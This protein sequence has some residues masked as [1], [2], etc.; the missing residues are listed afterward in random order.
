MS[1]TDLL[2]LV[3]STPLVELPRLSPKPGIRTFAKLEGQ[4]PTGSVKDRI[5]KAL[6]EEGEAQGLLNPGDT[7]VEASS[8][9]T[10]I[11]L[12]F[13][14]RQRGY[15]AR[16]VL[17]R[18]VAPSI[19]D[20]LAIYDV[21]ITWCRH[22]GGMRRAIDA[23]EEI[24]QAEGLYLLGQFKREA[25]V[26][27][28]YLTTGREIASALPRID[29]FVAGIGTGGTIMGVGRRLKETHPGVRIIGVEPKL[30]EQ[31]QGLRSI[32]EGFVPPLL[33]LD[34]LDGRYLVDTAS[35]FRRVKEVVA[36]EG[37]LAGASSGATLH[38]ALRV[39][40]GMDEGNIVVMFSDSGWKYIPARPWQD[41]DAGSEALDEVHWW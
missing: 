12:A 39:A 32:E 1:N 18:G 35:S 24:A 26:E 5:A 11:A 28:H 8:G 31:L 34:M 37:I 3:G 25:N 40:E 38:A 41:A 27:A 20:L 15:R 9:N 6:V 22:E 36:M 29:A 30:G 33:D 4:N 13:I 21:E 17:P 10:A 7:I 16:V 14:A 23:A 2:T 19:P